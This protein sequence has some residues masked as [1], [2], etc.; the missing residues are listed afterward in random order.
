MKIYQHNVVKR[1]EWLVNE[2]NGSNNVY[3]EDYI[4]EVILFGFIR[5]SYYHVN[6]VHDMSKCSKNSSSISGFSKINQY[7]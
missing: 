1:T 4:S 7:N 5:W 6:C 2:L 3:N